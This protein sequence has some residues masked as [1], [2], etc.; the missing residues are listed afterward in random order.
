MAAAADTGTERLYLSGHGKDDA[1]PWKFMCTS[2]AQSGYW[3]NLPVPSQWEMHGFGTLHY[4]K[5][6]PE[7]WNEKGLYR[8]DFTVPAGWT[9][10][11]VFLV[12]E[13][14][15]TDT[16][17]KLNG[18]S[19]GPIH[20]GGYYQFQYEVT[21]LVRFGETNQL[22]VAVAKHSAN[23]SVNRAE[24]DADY[25]VFGGI[26]RPVYLDA[27]P[28]WFIRRVAIDARAD[29][30]FT[31]EVFADG[32]SRGGQGLDIAAQVT[33][34]DGKP[35][36]PIFSA[37]VSGADG[38]V[39]TTLR[40]EINSPRAWS[41]ETPNLYRVQVWLKDGGRVLHH[42]QRRFGFRTIEIR[43]GEGIYLNGRRVI[44][45]GVC[46]HCFWPDSGR[47]LS[48]AAQRL[49]ANTIK[50]A[51]MNAVRTAHYPPDASFLDLCD[52]KG[53]Y[54]LDELAGWHQHYDNTVGPKLVRE[55][56]ARDVNHPC[57]LFWDNGNEGGFNTNLDHLFDQYDHQRRRVLHPWA[58]FD[59]FCTAHYLSYDQA[60]IACTG[61][62]VYYHKGRELVATNDPTR[63]IYMPT[64]FQHGLFDGG[65]GAGLADYWRLMTAS[66]RTGGGFIWALLDNAIR[67]PDTGVMDTAGNQAPD[68]ILGP[69]RQREASFYAIKEIWSP[70]VVTRRSGDTFQV[71]NHYSFLNADQ[72]RFAWQLRRFPQPDQDAASFVVVRQGVIEAPS[73][74]PG[75]R[76]LLI[77]NLPK[78]SARADALA[79][80]VDDPGG[81]RLWTWVW[82]TADADRFRSL[83]NASA[84]A[85]VESAE[86]ADNIELTSGNL[87]VGI[88]RQTGFLMEVRRG[89]QRFSLSNGPRPVPGD[90]KLMKLGRKRVG[91]DWEVTAQYVG[92]LKSVTW[93]LH[94]NG[95]LQCHYSFTVTG[96]RSYY[97]VAFDYPEKLVQ[98]KRWLGD[99]PYRV[100][101][102]R[103]HGVTFNVWENN[104][105]DTITGWRGWNYPEFKGCF[106]DV[107][108]LQLDT[109]EGTISVVPENVPFVQVLT[110]DFPPANLAGNTAPPVPHA[111]LAFLEAIPP[112][113]S[114]FKSAAETGPHGQP[115]VAR[116][117]YSGSVSFY[118]GKLP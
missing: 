64:E 62:S 89:S 116:G 4:H 15:M 24:R 85:P 39:E 44:L 57:V 29:G 13:G 18:Q 102:N 76:G 55:M 28:P 37:P 34:L 101:K 42:I 70:I 49:D 75:G 61:R 25:W 31:M 7:A 19:V 100:W 93:R 72:C 84:A 68:G 98:S 58:T 20:Q 86:T 115:N 69:Y 97:G 78:T 12:F 56:V 35:A 16:S 8:R 6:P 2:G 38:R 47:C 23:A 77:F 48:E 46:R 67:R 60:K 92:D 52:E 66:Q 54:V 104:Y 88:S 17:A 113:G 51:N 11:R 80:R 81:R 118:F 21:K 22:D 43:D 5:D 50:A 33:D 26:Y 32:I 79:L 107:R 114:K 27:V 71:E 59:G 9:G 30:A 106:A 96:P 91:A 74:P 83:L 40:T 10:R 90:A 95:W 63:Y 112:M 1:V 65:A 73:I 103:R 87:T 105:N 109:V 99:G 94:A 82:P 3:T 36:G 110:P 53:I 45:K 41:A 117:R 111:G 14:V 108:W